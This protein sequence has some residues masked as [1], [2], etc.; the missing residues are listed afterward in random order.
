MLEV[1]WNGCQNFDLTFVGMATLTLTLKSITTVSEFD[2]DPLDFTGGVKLPT[3]KCP[4]K[5]PTSFPENF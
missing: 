4:L 2:T 3:H 5:V 1:T